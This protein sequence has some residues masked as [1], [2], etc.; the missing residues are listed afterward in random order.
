LLSL[1]LP[2]FWK[3]KKKKEDRARWIG[4]LAYASEMEMKAKSLGKAGIIES[5]KS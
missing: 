2:V 1:L 3:K 4:L 5:L